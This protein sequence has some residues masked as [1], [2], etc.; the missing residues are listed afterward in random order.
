MRV[1]VPY[2]TIKVRD[3]RGQLVV[4][5]F[6]AD[7]PVPDSAD[8]DDVAR[9]LRKN[10]LVDDDA[11]AE[12]EPDPEPAGRPHGNASQATWLEYAVSKRAEG[13]SE[14][15]ARAALAEKTRAELVAEY[16]KE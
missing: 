11:K 5:E 16:G 4:R 3:D 10:C 12:P 2:C 6:Y 7:A 15:D 1:A 14:E 8:P 9:L 13:V